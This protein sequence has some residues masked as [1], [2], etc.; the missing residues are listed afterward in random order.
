MVV[1]DSDGVWYLSEGGRYSTVV[2][3][4]WLQCHTRYR[5]RHS[6]IP[7]WVYIYLFRNSHQV[8]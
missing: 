3:A 1:Q 4:G 6:I 7:Q 5:M 2:S 8:L